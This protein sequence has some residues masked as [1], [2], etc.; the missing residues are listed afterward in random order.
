MTKDC[1]S[2]SGI[3]SLFC[4]KFL[5]ETSHDWVR[6]CWCLSG[7]LSADLLFVIMIVFCLFIDCLWQELLGETEPRSEN[8]NVYWFMVSVVLYSVCSGYKHAEHFQ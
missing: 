3:C 2:K 4:V 5:F 8:G 6:M 1:R 7:W